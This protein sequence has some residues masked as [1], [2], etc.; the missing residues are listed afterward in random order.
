MENKYFTVFD[1]QI[2]PWRSNESTHLGTETGVTAFCMAFTHPVL[3]T[4]KIFWVLPWNVAEHV[5]TQATVI[6]ICH[7]CCSVL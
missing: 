2:F 4:S 6:V 1:E 5:L 7:P 3:N